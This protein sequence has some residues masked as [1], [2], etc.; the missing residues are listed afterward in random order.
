MK[1]DKNDQSQ[2]L[3]SVPQPKKSI[4]VSR[5]AKSSRR[6]IFKP[7]ACR[8]SDLDQLKQDAQSRAPRPDMKLGLSYVSCSPYRSLSSEASAKDDASSPPLKPRSLTRRSNTFRRGLMPRFISSPG[9]QGP[10]LFLDRGRARR[11]CRA[12]ANHGLAIV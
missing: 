5:M 11:P 10:G 1:T 6:T 4:G 8:Y 7:H 9:P 3:I 12:A 2:A